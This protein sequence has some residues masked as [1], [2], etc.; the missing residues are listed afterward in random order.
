MD[1]LSRLLA[2][3][4]I[5][6]AQP[7]P[8]I[9]DNLSRSDLAALFAK[10]EFKSGAEI[11]VEE[12]LYSE[13]LCR[14]NPALSLL[15]V[16]AWAMYPDYRENFGR[17]RME[18]YYRTAKKRL[19]PY[20]CRIVRAFSVDAVKDVE[21]ESL[22]FV[23]IDANHEYRAVVDDISY[24]GARVRPGGIV[25]GHD[26]FRHEPDRPTLHVIEAVTGYTSAYHIAPWF[27][28]TGEHPPSWFW[29][30]E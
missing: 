29:V 5:D 14:R 16:D 19:A 17:P 24:W 28:L 13:E 7:S 8:I 20:K 2:W 26:Y 10:L 27:V 25:A 18:S 1:T 6:P 4:T 3:W 11:G 23:Y 12:G 15:C 9:L 22:D 21:L 30:K